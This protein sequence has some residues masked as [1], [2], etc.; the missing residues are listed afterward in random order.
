MLGF[1]TMSTVFSNDPLPA[2]PDQQNSLRL[3]VYGK[4]VWYGDKHNF[5]LNSCLDELGFVKYHEEILRK[6]ISNFNKIFIPGVSQNADLIVLLYT[7]N[8]KNIYLYNPFLL[9]NNPSVDYIFAF[10]QHPDYSIRSIFRPI[11]L[12]DLVLPTYLV[13]SKLKN[14]IKD[15]EISKVIKSKDFSELLELHPLWPIFSFVPMLRPYEFCLI[16][17]HIVDPRFFAHPNRP[18][19][20]SKFYKFFGLHPKHLCLQKIPQYRSFLKDD[21]FTCEFSNEL[22]D[23][24]ISLIHSWFNKESISYYLKNPENPESFLWRIYKSKPSHQEGIWSATAYFLRF[25]VIFWRCI[26]SNHNEMVFLPERFFT[27]W[28]EARSFIY[29]TQSLVN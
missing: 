27:N 29:H 23:K 7:K 9:K 2:T 3:H 22:N 19:R 25:I 11:L 14:I 18:S 24:L 5:C 16:L 8:L 20:L 13:I 4:T 21:P 17:S 10:M 28:A 26:L 6:N 15:Q 12:N 1:L